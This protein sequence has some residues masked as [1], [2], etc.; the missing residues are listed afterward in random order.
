MNYNIVMLYV[1]TPSEVYIF[2]NHTSIIYFSFYLFQE[3]D[4]VEGM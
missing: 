4:G 3:L 2:F 1:T